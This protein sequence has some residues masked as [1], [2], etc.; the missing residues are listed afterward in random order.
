MVT[1]GG[2]LREFAD[3]WTP[4]FADP[5]RQYDYIDSIASHRRVKGGVR[6]EAR[7]QGGKTLQAELAFV[8]PEV[9]RLR[10]W[11]DEEPP[12][13]SPMLVEGAH[14]RYRPRLHADDGALIVDSGALKV[15]LA[16]AR[17][18][19]TVEDAHGRS[20]IEPSPDSRLLRTPFV[21]PLGFSREGSGGVAFHDAFALTPDERLYGLGEQ[22]G[23]FDRRGQRIVSWSRDPS[24]GLASPVCYMNV[25]FFLSSRGYGIF[26]HHSS[27]IVYELGQ[28]ALQSAA[29]RVNDPYL[30]YFFIYGPGPKQIIERYTGLTGRPLAPPLWS[31]GAWWSRCMYRDREQV[32]GIVERLRQLGIPGD[33]IHLDPLWLKERRSRELDGCD[34]VWDEEAFPDP[35][36]FVRWLGERGFKLSL[37]ENPY[38]WVNTEMHR[39]GVE[40]G[41][42]VRSQQGGLARPLENPDDTVL[43]DFTNPEAYR[44][45]QEKHRPYLRMGVA[46]FKPDYG[47]AVPADA[48]FADGRTGE[49]V[50]NIY[51]LLFN[52]CVYEVMREERG[53][54]MLFGR[55]GYAG[56]QRYP[57][58]WT[59]DQ[60]CT[61]G[62]MAAALRSGLSLS[63][64]GI[65]MW[66]HDIGGFWN[67]DNMQPP[68]PTLYIRWAQ[69]GLLSSHARFHGVRGREPWYFGDKAVQVVREFARLRYRLLPYIY[70]LA[71]EAEETGLPVVRP[72]VLEYPD[73]PVAP[74]VDYEYL[75]GPYLLV[76]PVTNDEGRCL[77]YLPP[78]VWYDWWNGERLEGPRHLQLGVPLERLPLYVRGDSLLVMAPQM[79]HVGQRDWRPLTVDVRLS[80]SAETTVWSPEQPMTLSADRPD[81][82]VRLRL[83]GP[84]WD[85]R[86]RFLQPAVA[87]DVRVGGDASGLAV[88]Q[89]DGITVV[90][91]SGGRFEL[92]VDAR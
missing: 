30:D 46:A 5:N 16:R 48:L 77:V 79:E 47:E 6:L 91:V 74:A 8:T 28:P 73:D 50:H 41:Y 31:F 52:R 75:L 67:P 43:L 15:R 3:D 33:V 13:D 68:D 32:E 44:W 85:Y 80:G 24:G 54:V 65:S 84:P 81:G 10:A 9:F 89:E 23:P 39:E 63:L 4:I 21:L 92:R 70:S 62:G 86:V 19:L 83:S 37:W 69:F 42:F 53:E 55:S 88:R 76:A 20:L 29:F 11:L 59:G 22:F 71:K 14:S 49:Q 34:F 7:T 64:S 18:G 40:K 35:E 58:N 38:V 2:A 61:W 1:P 78:G 57:I 36:G 66:S 82:E 72:L 87:A 17:W 45:W 25:P 27:K 26:L 56:S 90:D 51:P 60:P 12:A